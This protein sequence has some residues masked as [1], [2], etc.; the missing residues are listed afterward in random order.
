MLLGLASFGTV[1]ITL[2][3][4]APGGAVVIESLRQAVEFE[5]HTF[6]I[7]PVE[8]VVVEIVTEFRAPSVGNSFLAKRRPASR[9]SFS[10]TSSASL[11]Y[12]A[13]T[14]GRSDDCGKTSRK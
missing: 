12:I 11:P 3:Y 9:V 14:L 6:A 7:V 8:S 13:K 5:G 2:E 10:A 1:G 4:F